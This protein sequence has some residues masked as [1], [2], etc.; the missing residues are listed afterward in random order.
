MRNNYLWV[1][2]RVFPGCT[3]EKVDVCAFTVEHL[4]GVILEEDIGGVVSITS[5]H[6]RADWLTLYRSLLTPAQLT[7]L[8]TGE[9]EEKH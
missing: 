9:A 1:P 8:L 3:E 6:G 5:W 7:G 2:T 4:S